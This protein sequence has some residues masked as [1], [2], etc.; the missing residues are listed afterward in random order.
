MKQT[1]IQNR[2]IRGASHKDGSPGLLYL[3]VRMQRADRRLKPVRVDLPL[4]TAS[5]AEAA[6]LAPLLVQALRK[7]GVPVLG[8]FPRV[9]K[10]GKKR[11]PKTD[12]QQSPPL[13]GMERLV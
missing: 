3:R 8:S 13:P 9:K 5:R 2:I 11:A 7:A 12:K 4:C 6:R 10:G 1:D